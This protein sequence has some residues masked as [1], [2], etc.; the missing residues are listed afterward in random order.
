VQQ[1]QIQFYYSKVPICT[2]SSRNPHGLILF[3]LLLIGPSLVTI[4]HVTLYGNYAANGIHITNAD[5]VILISL[6]P[7]PYL[8][9]SNIK[10]GGRVYVEDFRP[11]GPTVHNILANYLDNV[12]LDFYNLY[13]E[14]L[15]DSVGMLSVGGPCAAMGIDNY[16]SELHAEI[17]CVD[18][19]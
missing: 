9:I 7:S 6:C 19:C 13:V 12:H 4:K 1:V 14:G 16:Y 15:T 3:V 18:L 17:I 8:L 10:I 5:Q 11:Y 2:N